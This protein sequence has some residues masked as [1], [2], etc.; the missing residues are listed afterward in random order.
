MSSRIS[1][2][3]EAEAEIIA[4]E[5]ARVVYWFKIPQ[6]LAAQTGIKKVGLMENTSQEE[7]MSANRAAGSQNQLGLEL[8]RQS[9]RFA[10][11]SALN[12]GDGSSEIFWGKST[13]GMA[14]I[15]QLI[16]G[17]YIHIHNAD[18]EETTSFLDSMATS[19]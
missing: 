12:M 19:A 13:P 1:N 7:L 15:R 4:N 17:A 18:P 6:K 3:H 14:K 8:A 11:D 10:D 9:L 2:A 16:L 5:K